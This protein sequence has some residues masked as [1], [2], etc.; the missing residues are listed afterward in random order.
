MKVKVPIL[1][2]ILIVANAVCF[3]AQNTNPADTQASTSAQVQAKI[4]SRS[5]DIIGAGD[6][7]NIVELSSEE[8]TKT[9]HVSSSGDLELPLVGKL[10]VAGLTTDQ[11]AEKLTSSLKAYIRDPQVTVYISE[12]RSRPVTIAGA[13]HRPG[14]YQADSG[15][16]LLAVIQMAAGLDSPGP[17]LLV[18]RELKYGPLPLE[19]AVKDPDGEHTSANILIKDVTN[20]STPAS[21]LLVQPHDVISVQTERHMIYVVGEVNKPGVIE[22]VTQN[23]L[24]LVQTLATAGGLTRISSPRNAEIMRQDS[25]GIYKIVSKVD[26]KAVITGK[27]ED[28]LLSPGDILFVPSSGVKS[29]TQSASASLLSTGTLMLARF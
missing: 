2:A 16:T 1:F 15:T 11:L 28:R 18:T 6:S 12:S 29:F 10:H 13:V 9:W 8:L 5:D 17:N 19:G 4:D 27:Q 25:T 3:A 20:P 7:M 14:T 24:S 21:N 23:T 22:L 26:L